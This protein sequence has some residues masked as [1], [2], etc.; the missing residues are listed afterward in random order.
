MHRYRFALARGPALEA[1]ARRGSVVTIGNY[2]GVHLGHQAV[3]Q[4]ARGAA[5]RLSLPTV[6][7][8]FEP[9]PR[10]YFDPVGAPP[11]LTRLRE[12]YLLLREIGID[13]VLCLRFGARLAGQ[14]P[15]DFV[16]RFLIEGLGA[17]ALTVGQDFRFGRGR[18]GDHALLCALG[19]ARGIEVMAVPSYE[20]DGARISSTRVREALG[21]GDLAGASRLLGRPYAIFGRIAHGDQRGRQLGC[22]TANIPLRRRSA[23]LC[24]IFVVAV[25]GLG[26]EALPGV[27]Y[28]GSRPAVGGTLAVL[29]VHLLDFDADLYGELVWVEFLHQLREDRMFDSL[30]GL[31]AQIARDVEEARRFWAHSQAFGERAA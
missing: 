15:E 18:R 14:A 24:G 30:E 22:A 13:H 31:G 16:E 28:V 6:A 27:A 5:A 3:L 9:Q 7:L 1:V 8:I 12:K 21:C 19:Q 23:A 10:E 11:R 2:D 17:R 25:R 20:Q 4:A 26:P 29:E